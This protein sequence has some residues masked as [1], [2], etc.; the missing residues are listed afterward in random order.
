MFSESRIPVYTGY[1]HIFQGEPIVKRK[2]SR[3]SSSLSFI[4]TMEPGLACSL[5]CGGQFRRRNPPVDPLIT[6]GQA[7]GPVLTHDIDIGV[8][9]NLPG[10]RGHDLAGAGDIFGHDQMANE[11]SPHG[12]P[13]F[14]DLEIADLAVHLQQG[15]FRPFPV[16]LDMTE[17][18]A[19]WLSQNL[20][21]GM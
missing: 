15:F 6:R 20:K 3:R 5:F 9:G 11:Q 1:R 21:S 2:S 13:L 19:H 14:V 18:F 16:I 17:A 7:A 8:R 4:Q 12:Q 10:E